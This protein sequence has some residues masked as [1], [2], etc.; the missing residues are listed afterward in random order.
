MGF[1]NPIL[2]GG[3]ALVR[4]AIKSPGYV[5]GVSGWSV[6]RDGDA[7]FNDI[8]I[9]EG[10]TVS[11]L[12]LYYDGTPAAGNL[13]LSIAAAA[14]V[15]DFGNAY[16]KGL[17]VGTSGGQMVQLTTTVGGGAVLLPTGVAAETLIAQIGTAVD[18][19]SAANQQLIFQL[20]GPQQSGGER[21]FAQML[22]EAADGSVPARLQLV[23]GGGL[24]RLL[25]VDRFQAQVLPQ[26]ASASSALFVNTA[27]GHTGRLLRLQLNGADRFEVSA[28][29]DV[30]AAGIV[31]K[32]GQTWQA[33]SYAANWTGGS[34]ASARYKPLQYRLDAEDNLHVCGAART[35]AALAAG[36]YTLFTLPAGY[37]PTDLYSGPA[38]QVSSADAWKTAVRFN[39]DSTG[40]VGINTATA[41]ASG[42]GIYANF[43]VPMGNLT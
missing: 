37:R 34:L 14:G 9:R 36:S 33:P 35:T 21:V 30:A 19:R 5:P 29:G 42:D 2:G 23:R 4:P 10:T 38:I 11:G 40:A 39:I 31:S 41:L 27:S 17:A 12:A 13:I 15:D 26:V 3:G 7:E 28:A 20:S 6:N 25:V 32:T 8:T 1:V 24:Q 22:S 18:N 16:P 43:V